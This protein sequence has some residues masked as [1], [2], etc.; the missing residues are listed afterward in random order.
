MSSNDS[1]SPDHVFV[2]SATMST[3]NNTS[4]VK[5]WEMNYFT[6]VR[7][8]KDCQN[9]WQCNFCL[10]DKKYSNLTKKPGYFRGTRI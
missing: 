5:H 4:N 2:S 10:N 7:A 6:V 8:D 9:W 3:N 1:T